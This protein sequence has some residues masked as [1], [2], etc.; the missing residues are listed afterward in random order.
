MNLESSNKNKMFDHV[1]YGYNDRCL[2]RKNKK[3]K[4]IH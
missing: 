4:E 2:F 3:A 1:L